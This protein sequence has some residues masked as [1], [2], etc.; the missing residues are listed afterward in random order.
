ALLDQIPQMI[1]RLRAGLEA[2]KAKGSAAKGRIVALEKQKKEKELELAKHEE[3]ARKHSAQLNQVK[4]NDAFKALQQEI[5]FAKQH[6]GDIE[7]EILQ[8]MESLDEARKQDK[9]VQAELGV[10]AKKFEAEIAG[11][12]KRLAERQAAFDAAKAVRDEAAA[13][14]PPDVLRVYDHIRGRGKPDAV[15]PIDNSMCS[16]CRIS[17]A[18]VVIVEATKLKALV[19]CESC[20]RILYR[21][22]TLA[23]AKV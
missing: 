7:T 14:I 21:P 12:Q 9:T 18:P 4:T 22:E 6:A 1:E 5:G 15:V 17:L 3:E 10:E 23:P 19:I 8:L 11:H 2:E 20:Q 16:A 13:P